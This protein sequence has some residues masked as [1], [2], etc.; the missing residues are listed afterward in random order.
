MLFV[1]VE[2]LLIEQNRLRDDK[3]LLEE[4]LALKEKALLLQQQ[5]A[6]AQ[7]K[8]GDPDARA[9]RR[10]HFCGSKSDSHRG[11]TERLAAAG[12]TGRKGKQQRSIRTDKTGFVLRSRTG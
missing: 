4:R 3:K 2:R 1:Q 9:C 5:M 6:A 7:I 8:V 10:K 11:Q 12:K